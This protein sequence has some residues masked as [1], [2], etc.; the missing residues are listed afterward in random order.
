MRTLAAVA[1][2]LVLGFVCVAPVRGQQMSVAEYQRKSTKDAKKQEKLQKKADKNRT[3][4]LKKMNKANKKQ[5]AKDK[6]SDEKAN[7]KL[8][9]GLIG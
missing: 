1:L 3:K 7:R 8:H 5:A 2:G 9:G 4:A 6:K